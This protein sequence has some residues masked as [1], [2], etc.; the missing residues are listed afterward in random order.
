MIC[1]NCTAEIPND[2]VFCINCGTKVTSE[3]TELSPVNSICQYCGVTIQIESNFCTNCGKPL[4]ETAI[5]KI[6]SQNELDL[7]KTQLKIQA[8][9]LKT[10]QENL[11]L[12]QEQ[13]DSMAKCPFCGSTSLSGNKKGFGIG[14]AVVGAWALGPIGL[15]AGN[16]GAKKVNV[17]C[18]NCGK[19]FRL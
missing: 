1:P 9:A 4:T 18:L 5:A 19:R 13:F 14:K 7:Q 12:Q 17:T 10:Q 3:N 11:Q 8:V 2:S 16:I 15:M 6:K